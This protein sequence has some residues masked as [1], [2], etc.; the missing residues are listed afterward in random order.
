MTAPPPRRWLAEPR[1]GRGIRLFQN[2]RGWEYRE[3]AEV[4][5]LARRVGSA[6]AADGVGPGDVVCILLPTGF[7]CLAAFFG[8]WVAGATPCL[9][10]PPGV[11]GEAHYVSAVA[12]ILRQAAPKVTVTSA[13]LARTAAAA[14][15]AAGRAGPPWLWRQDPAPADPADVDPDDNA[16]LQFTSG[17]T[18]SPCG[19][20]VSWANLSANVGAIRGWLGWGDGDVVTSWLPLCHDM[21]LIGA[22]LSSV[23]SQTDLWLMEP[24]DFIRDPGRWLECMTFSSFTVAPSFGYE[25]V[26]RR[27]RPERLAGLDLS[28]CRRAIV[29]AEPIDPVTLENFARLTEPAGFSRAAFVPAYGMAEATLVITAVTDGKTRRVVRPDPATLDVGQRVRIQREVRR[30]DRSGQGW[31]VSCGRPVSETRVTVRDMTGRELPPEHVGEIA[32][33]GPSV[34]A[35]YYAARSGTST[36][37]VDGELRTADAGFLHDGELFVLGRMGDSLKLR[38]RSVFVADLESAVAGLDGLSRQRCAVV[39]MADAS[40]PGVVL[41]AEVPAGDWVPRARDVLLGCLGEDAEIRIVTGRPGLIR[42]TT[43][44]KPRRREMWELFRSGRVRSLS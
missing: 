2:G 8:A 35:G 14:L 10:A 33:R 36:R 18:G 32:V 22:L 30:G 3:Y 28:G 44:G 23:I 11:T 27:V 1:P 43:S 42:R 26:V 13:K 25:Y 24:A 9:V 29:G 16:L 7:P 31:L 21:G 17:S 4:A 38:G 6:L 39:S 34:T 20:Q 41:F 15:A 12:A 5:G 40:R 19:V 37:F